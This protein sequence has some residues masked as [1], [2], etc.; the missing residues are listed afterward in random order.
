MIVM[1]ACSLRALGNAPV[2]NF[3]TNID[4]L[5]NNGHCLALST[6]ELSAA[7]FTM[8]ATDKEPAH[9]I[10]EVQI[11]FLRISSVLLLRM[12]SG[13]E[14]EAADAV[15]VVLD[16]FVNDSTFLTADVMEAY[17]PYSLIRCAYSELYKKRGVVKGRLPGASDSGF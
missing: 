16:A 8:T 3:R 9:A 1:F 12:Q 14:R 7:F 11:E 4:A 6:S 2:S 15:Y 13:P 5:E 17:F 10:T